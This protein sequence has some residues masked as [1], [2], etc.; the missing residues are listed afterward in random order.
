MVANLPLGS[1]L[2]LCLLTSEEHGGNCINYKD[3]SGGCAIRR[4]NTITQLKMGYAAI[5]ESYTVYTKAY[6]CEFEFPDP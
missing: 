5:G 4:C 1:G 3:S 6:G 2:D